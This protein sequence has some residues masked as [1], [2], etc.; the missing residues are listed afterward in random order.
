[1]RKPF[2]IKCLPSVAIS[3]WLWVDPTLQPSGLRTAKL[4][5]PKTRLTRVVDRYISIK[6]ELKWLVFSP[7]STSLQSLS[8]L[9][10][11]FAVRRAQ[12]AAT[13]LKLQTSD[14]RKRIE[15]A[16]QRSYSRWPSDI[17]LSDSIRFLDQQ[18]QLYA[19][20]NNAR[21]QAWQDLCQSLMASSEFLYVE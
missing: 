12:A 10:S 14:D 1:M 19:E 4:L 11:D 15:M 8:L 21:E 5:R 20:R 17:E 16:F 3:I 7:S 13:L 9:N 2:A 18:T 6:N